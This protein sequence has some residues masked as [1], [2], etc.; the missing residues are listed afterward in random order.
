MAQTSLDERI[1]E[2]EQRF[3]RQI[4]EL[5]VKVT[6]LSGQLSSAQPSGD[7]AWW[8]RIVGVYRDDPEFD[9]AM[10]LGR[11]YRDSLR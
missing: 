4:A 8:K 6:D 1:T 2:L 3:S 5:D 11:E 7:Q 10:R 9:E